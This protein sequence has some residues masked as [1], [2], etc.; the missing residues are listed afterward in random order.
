MCHHC[1]DF[2]GDLRPES[3]GLSDSSLTTTACVLALPTHGLFSATITVRDPLDSTK[4]P[5]ILSCI[6]LE[7]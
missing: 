6:L 2:S 5:T 7:V 1:V 4:P 3:E